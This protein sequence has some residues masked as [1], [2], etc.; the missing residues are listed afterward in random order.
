MKKKR[1]ITISILLVFLLVLL[2][3]FQLGNK[4]KGFALCFEGEVERVIDGD[5]LKIGGYTVR[6]SLVD[7]PERGEEG[8]DEA[9]K[10][11]E[12]LCP[13]GSRVLVD[14]D[15]GQ[16]FDTYGRLIGVVY[17]NGKN[18]NAELILNGL[19]KVD[20]RFCLRSEFSREKW[21]TTFCGQ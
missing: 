1:I 8:F 6:L 15:D 18:L 17:C 13:V 4:C 5:T 21:A 2:L 7:T 3:Y 14:Q 20:E 12:N 16:R 11:T 9:K 10:F 19:G